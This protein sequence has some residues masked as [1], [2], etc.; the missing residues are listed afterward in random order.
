MTDAYTHN[1]EKD[2]KGHITDRLVSDTFPCGRP[3]AKANKK[4]PSPL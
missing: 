3:Y 2:D 4:T 1:E